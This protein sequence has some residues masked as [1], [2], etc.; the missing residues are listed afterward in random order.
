MSS[1]CIQLSVL[2]QWLKVSQRELITQQSW[3]LHLGTEKRNPKPVSL[4]APHMQ[5]CQPCPSAHNP[6]LWSTTA[7]AHM[8]F[9]LV[10]SER[11][12]FDLKFKGEREIGWASNEGRVSR[13]KD[14]AAQM[15]G[16]DRWVP[17]SAGLA[18]PTLRTLRP[19]SDL[20]QAKGRMCLRT[21]DT[22]DHPL[23]S[24]HVLWTHVSCTHVKD[25]LKYT[26]LKMLRK[27]PNPSITPSC[28]F[29]MRSLPP[30]TCAP[31]S[32]S[33]GPHWSRKNVGTILSISRS[34][35][36]ATLFTP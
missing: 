30:H 15:R 16:G 28:C 9:P 12:S 22:W 8:K 19:M 13:R 10:A 17:R 6:F 35:S 24:I 23:T 3:G 14:T 36:Y 4:Q 2:S 18:W 5:L 27:K 21:D 20:S 33:W 32:M 29:E 31:D 34:K 7:P 1:C 11:L 25:V 26:H